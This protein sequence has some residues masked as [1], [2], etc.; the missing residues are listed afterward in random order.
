MKLV[1]VSGLSGSGKTVAL[2]TLEDAGFYCIDNL[3]VDLLPALTDKLIQHSDGY[4]QDTAIGIDA[5]T[6]SSQLAA[7]PHIARKLSNDGL[8]CRILFLE[9]NDDVLVRRFKETRRRHPLTLKKT[10]LTTAID[11]ERNM[12]SQVCKH[13]DFIIDTSS[14]TLHEL[15][16]KVLT[17]VV[18]H[19]ATMQIEIKSFGFKHGI[20]EDAD[21]MFDARCL[22]NPHWQPELRPLT[23][24]DKA[25]QD[26]LRKEPMSE[27]MIQQLF[28]FITEWLPCFRD[29]GRSYFTI[30]VGCTGGQH[31]SVFIVEE[32][33]Q[34]L[35]ERLDDEVVIRH[36]ELV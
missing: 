24:R 11:A 28:H 17:E 16:R 30:A 26:F 9:A 36:R 15:R 21:L 31:R 14:L 25:V 2:R 1:I 20:A 4:H 34:R 3:P 12:L 7:L 6:V 35:N 32:L 19:A 10:S 13:A 27:K 23:G 8:D 33:A 18:E 5:R 22:P 29:E